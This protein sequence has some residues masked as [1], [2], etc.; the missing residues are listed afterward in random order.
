[1]VEYDMM[2]PEY[3]DGISEILCDDCHARFGRWAGKE[4]AEGE[5]EKR[6]GKK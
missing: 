2:H 5:Y 1:M 3:Y 4:L 6:Y